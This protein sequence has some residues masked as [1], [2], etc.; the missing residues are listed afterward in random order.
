MILKKRMN[1]KTKMLAKIQKIKDKDQLE[2][3]K[4]QLET[5]LKA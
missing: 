1:Q 2:K 3:R 5:F 4:K